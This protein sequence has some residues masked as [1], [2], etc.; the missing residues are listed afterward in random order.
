MDSPYYTWLLAELAEKHHVPGAQ[1]ALYVDGKPSYA[2][3]G[4]ER[5]GNGSPVSR[6]SSFAFGSVTK[7]FTATV[8]LQLVRD[9]DIELDEPISTYIPEVG[10]GPDDIGGVVTLRTLLSHTSGLQAEFDPGGA[11]AASVRRY[12]HACR[13]LRLLFPPGTGFSYSNAGFV[14]AGHLIEVMAGASWWDTVESLLLRPLTIEPVFA[15]DPRVRPARRPTA[16]GH[17]LHP[18]RQRIIPIDS[19]AQVCDAPAGGLAGSAADLLKFGLAQIGAVP[20]LTGV[21]DA[22]GMGMMREQVAGAYPY[23]LAAGWGL[24]LSRFQGREEMWFGHDGTADGSTC[25]LRF[26]PERRVVLAVTTNATTGLRLWDGVLRNLREAGLD[27]G[28]YSAP[29]IPGAGSPADA[30]ACAGDYCNGDIQYAVRCAADGGLQ[31]VDDVPMSMRVG[32]DLVFT[33][34]NPA[35]DEPPSAG[36]FVRDPGTGRIDLMEINGRAARRCAGNVEVQHV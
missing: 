26:Q 3:T 36:R 1:L 30:S 28:S 4:Q 35:A 19:L 21:L 16:T 24:G 18:A 15:A 22:A 29:V 14:L 34:T 20:E 5:I 31:L 25:H 27:I 12:V 7:P 10:G 17:T 9:G 23:G 32:S 13:D 33:A 11:A 2:E 6:E 8:A